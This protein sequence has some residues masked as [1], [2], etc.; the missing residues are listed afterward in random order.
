MKKMKKSTKYII[1]VNFF[2]IILLSIIS[3]YEE[4]KYIDGL[5]TEYKYVEKNMKVFEIVKEFVTFK[6]TSNI[7]TLSGKKIWIDD[8]S[9]FNYRP[10]DLYKFL[11]IGDTIIK[12]HDS[13]TLYI[14]R[15]KKEYYFVLKKNVGKDTQAINV[16]KWFKK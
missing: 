4:K 14:H 5:N 15:N 7:E 6:G 9:N 11:Q 13:D 12:H 16:K 2:I 3:T 1:G 8:A 10:F